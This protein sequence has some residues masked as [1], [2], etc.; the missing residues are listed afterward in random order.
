MSLY[1]V[2][3]LAGWGGPSSAG[4]QCPAL[5]TVTLNVVASPGP[6][7]TGSTQICQG[8]TTTLNVPGTFSS[9]AWSTGATGASIT[10]GAGTYFVTVTNSSGCTG[11]DE[12]TVT[13]LSGPSPD[14]TAATYQCNGQ[15]LLDAGAGYSIYHWSNNAA[16]QT[17]TATTNG[18]YSVTVTDASGCTGT[19]NFTVAIPPPPSVSITGDNVICGNESGTLDATPGFNAYAWSNGLQGSTI[20]VTQPGVYMVTATDG[21][22][23]TDDAS[24]TITSN[25]PPAPNITGQ[26]TICEGAST[27]LAIAGSFPQYVWSTGQQTPTISVSAAGQ[28][29]VTVTAANGCT[30]TDQFQL[31]VNDAPVP[32]IQ[33]AP[34]D[35]NG[36]LTL[37]AE[38]GF[39]GYA[40]STGQT[41]AAIDVDQS[42]LYGVTVTNAF[43]CT[44]TDVFLASIPD[45]PLVQITGA[46]QFCQ[47][48]S[49]TL[50]ATPG[51]DAYAWS[52]GQTASVVQI[53]QGGIYNLT[54]TDGFGCTA[55][56]AA[57]VTQL[58]LPA[59]V[60][61]G[62]T[63]ICFNSTATFSVANG[64]SAYAWSNGS[65]GTS[66]T[67]SAPDTYSVTVTAA[68]GCMGADDIPLTVTNNLQAQIVAQPY[69][70]NGQLVLD[71]GAGFASYTWSGGQTGSSISVGQSG[72]YNVTISD[73]GGCTGSAVFT[74]SIPAPPTV[75]ISGDNALCPGESTV[76]TASPGLAA[77][78]WSGGQTGSSI[79]VNQSGNYVV[80]ATD[81][82]GCTVA[83]N[84]SVTDLQPPQP[85]ITGPAS[86][87]INATASFD[88]TG[89]FTAYQWSTGETTSGIVTG[90][91]G[92]Y[93]VTV[94]ASNGCTGSNTA[95]LT[96]TNALSPDIQALPYQC[97]AQL[98]L[99]AGTGFSTYQWS[100][101]QSTSTITVSQSGVYTVT[102][103][104]SGG[105]TGTDSVMASIPQAPVLGISGSAS[106]CA[107]ASST[108]S[109]SAGFTNYLWSDGSIGPVL[110]VNQSGSYA[111]TATDVLG[112]TQTAVMPVT[113][114]PLPAPQIAGL[115]AV[116]AGDAA[117]LSAGSGFNSYAWSTG[118]TTASISVNAA[119]NF[120]LT[121]SDAEGCTGTAQASFSL[122]PLPSPAI[123]AQTYQCDGQLTLDGGAGFAAYTW[124]GG[125]NSPAI[126]VSN[127]GSY[128]LT[129]TDPNGCTGTTQLTVSVP[130]LSTVSIAGDPDFCQG[131]STDLTASAGFVAYAWSDGQTDAAITANQG[132]VY[133]VTATD[134]L[135]CTVS[136]QMPLTVFANPAPVIAGPVAV[137]PGAT[138]TLSVPGSFADFQW[139]QTGANGNTLVFQ[140][141]GIATVTVTDA[142]GCTGIASAT[143]V[144][145][146]TLAPQITA[147]PF[148]CDGQ[149]ILD[150]GAG[151]AIYTWSNGQGSPTLSV[152]QSGTYAVT[153]SDGSGCSGMASIVVDVPAL[154]LVTVGGDDRLCPGEISILTADAGF[155]NYSWSTGAT[156]ETINVSQSGNYAVTIT[157]LNG[158]TATTALAVQSLAAPQPQITGGTTICS[159]NAITISLAGS[160][161]Q[162]SWSTGATAGSISTSQP[163]D[164]AVTVTD[165]DGCTGT[166]QTSLT[167]GGA[168][169]AVISPQPY[170][171]D[172]QI[173]LQATAGFSAYVW[174]NGQTTP[175]VAVTQ[176]GSYAVT[177]SDA[178]GCSGTA[179][180]QATLPLPPV[181]TI[182]GDEQICQG[183]TAALTASPGFQ[184][185][186]WSNGPVSASISTTQAGNYSVTVTDADG[187]TAVALAAVTVNLPDTTL[188]QQ[189]T[190]NPQQAGTTVLTFNAA[191]GCDSVVVTQTVLNPQVSGAAAVTSDYNSFAVAC[192][193]G[194]NGTA[195]ANPAGG[196]PPFN[197]AWSN[198]GATAE[199]QNLS[200]GNYSVTM[201]D[202]NGCTATATVSLNQPALL[203]PVVEA[204]DP[205]CL[206]AGHV[207]VQVINGG[208]G[209]YHVQ[210]GQNTG[211]SNGTEPLFFNGL[212]AGSY[213]LEVTDANGCP[214]QETVT[215]LPAPAVEEFVSDTFE[216]NRG[217][218]V[219]LDA[220]AGITIQ[221][222]EITWTS[223]G[224]QLSCTD[225]LDPQ[226][227]PLNTT[228]V[229]LYVEGYSGC[230]AAGRYLIQVKTGHLIY[231]PNAIQPGSTGNY[232]L[233]VFG[234]EQL[235]RIR[236]LQVYDRWGNE[237][238]A[239]SDI[240]PND[241]DL[242]WD[243]RFRG[244]VM[245][246]GVYVW[247]AELEYSDGT[248]EVQKGDVTL[249]H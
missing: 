163:G 226:I 192:A 17:I 118:E 87:C 54:A 99:D 246:P 199:I 35:C 41:D 49:T 164:Y 75:T 39:A 169:N 1:V 189:T 174:S 203:Q 110:V 141:P 249:V 152:T 63:S 215:L 236:Q 184:Q 97:N 93:A 243:G 83:N 176:S 8:S 239:I 66:I 157:D 173:T 139:S 201:T 74:A 11:T 106:F 244:Q 233:T 151:F 196:T 179:S 166:A 156:T 101:G 5:A 45:P 53:G 216:I 67:V 59:P 82:L 224:G 125:Q 232:G 100:D 56:T 119:G 245:M 143:V 73:A 207:A 103:T 120:S 16:T 18:S 60:I 144:I 158:C 198:G 123:T 220:G 130:A 240:P 165:A 6:N 108:L 180:I 116:C 185:Y 214:A 234:D 84:M 42:D 86:I 71:A 107:D 222:L 218:T 85:L 37:D 168:I 20:T 183:Q 181:V 19:D 209:P 208:A 138:A 211:T 114:Q 68:N 9:Y 193:G 70:C 62:P 131:G 126:T 98:S 43:G 230:Q 31:D 213:A 72:D 147:L 153:V 14:I 65:S 12:E 47:G 26:G 235:V 79:T 225:C 231:V 132:G 237:L 242:G 162:Y 134:A 21:F 149:I 36:Q 122:Y 78:L 113:A 44:G 77:Y 7:I 117:T 212:D 159:G 190:C 135:G 160:F 57:T 172:G 238:A 32:T 52:G 109:A 58:A 167:A 210:L 155:A 223:S 27:T 121:V 227:A 50:T 137:C 30:G 46:L 241:P 187:C 161:D 228:T 23:C 38:G 136:A 28:Y 202:A 64:F 145:S 92:Q 51:F 4:A 90:T 205:T 217:D 88:A 175:A 150:A 133:A 191:N 142:N 89:N 204:A 24:F 25:A 95:S 112:C 171:C 177:V 219:Q 229:E 80:T 140:P 194:A 40:W 188:Q 148:A 129:V 104:G 48:Q 94:T 102:V 81:N 105:C 96:V 206:E 15:L 111:L 170:L 76:L 178:A 200:A 22:G 221:A 29:S 146:D 10:V 2:L 13:L 91:A 195:A 154:P 33:A 3:F 124:S 182:S 115:P 247:W 61:S 127:S 128:A 69:Q 197:Y 34:Y 248:V 55:T 186:N